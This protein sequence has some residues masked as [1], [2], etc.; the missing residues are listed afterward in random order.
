M[1]ERADAVNRRNLLD[2]TIARTVPT[3]KIT[4][5]ASAPTR[6][7]SRAVAVGSEENIKRDMGRGIPHPLLRPPLSASPQTLWT[8][9][10]CDMGAWCGERD[11]E[12]V[13]RRNGAYFV[14]PHHTI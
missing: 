4:S 14:H 5:D 8:P 3:Y 11:R 12:L 10:P 1:Q 6:G 13:W 2:L 7:K 9:L